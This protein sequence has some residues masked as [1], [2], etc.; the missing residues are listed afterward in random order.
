MMSNRNFNKNEIDDGFTTIINNK[1]SSY[2]MI[3]EDYRKG[4][5]SLDNAEK[6][7]NT[8]KTYNNYNHDPHF[9]VTKNGMIALYNIVH[10]PLVLYANQWEK[11]GKFLQ[12]NKDSQLYKYIEE[13]DGCIKKI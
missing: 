12:C 6:M 13:N 10:K 4:K 11:L 8:K 2:K 1:R 9:R 7:L 5:I 3:L